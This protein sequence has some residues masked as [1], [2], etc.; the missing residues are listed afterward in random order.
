MTDVYTQQHAPQIITGIRV[1]PAEGEDRNRLLADISEWQKV[2]PSVAFSVLPEV[3]DEVLVDMM[4]GQFAVLEVVS[5]MHW[6]TEVRGGQT[7]FS[8][9]TDWVDV[10]LTCRQRSLAWSKENET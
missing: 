6:A 2:T 1:L 9:P 10:T 4:N 7:S 3:G 8:K 5:R